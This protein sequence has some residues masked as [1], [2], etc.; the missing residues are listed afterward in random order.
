MVS[1]I[2][3]SQKVP[4][5]PTRASSS[6][7]QNS[8]TNALAGFSFSCIGQEPSFLK[9][10]S[11][12]VGMDQDEELQY[13]SYPSTPEPPAVSQVAREPV[14]N[15]TQSSTSTIAVRN[16]RP[17]RETSHEHDTAYSAYPNTF[18]PPSTDV[19]SSAHP[20]PSTHATKLT[21][22]THR[23][24]EPNQS[25]RADTMR[26]NSSPTREPSLPPQ[27]DAGL[28]S[29]RP[30]PSTS[31]GT[32]THTRCQGMRH[33]LVTQAA[34]PADLIARISQVAS[35]KVEWSEVKLLMQRYRR[36][37]DELLR[38][39]D[40]SARA[41]QKEREQAS[42][43]SAVADDAFGKFEALLLRHE[44]RLAFEQ[45][46]AE[47]ALTEI[48]SVIIDREARQAP[49]VEMEAREAV[50]ARRAQL[51]AA[52]RHRATEEGA[53]RTVEDM[54]R[55]AATE[56]R[57]KA[58]AERE[59]EERERLEADQQRAEEALRKAAEQRR[60][61]LAA[62][63]Q[64]Q[65]EAAEEERRTKYAAQ[66]AAAELEKR[67]YLKVQRL[68]ARRN[69]E[70][71]PKSANERLKARLEEERK[72]A[73][74]RSTSVSSSGALAP[75]KTDA[76]KERGS[77]YVA[78]GPPNPLLPVQPTVPISFASTQ[79][80]RIDEPQTGQ[81]NG[82]R[83]GHDS[84]MAADRQGQL[85]GAISSSVASSQQVVSDL[86]RN[87]Q[88]PQEFHPSS[89]NPQDS[90][91][92][93]NVAFRSPSASST[94]AVSKAVTA[95][96]G[97]T[98]NEGQDSS[99]S[100]RPVRSDP[101]ITAVQGVVKASYDGPS[102]QP[103]A[104]GNAQH[105]NIK[106]E[107]P[108][109]SGR[110]VGRAPQVPVP[111]A[112]TFTDRAI[113][114]HAQSLSCDGSSKDM[115]P[116]TVLSSTSNSNIN[117][118]NQEGCPTVSGSQDKTAPEPASSSSLYRR[119]PAFANTSMEL[120]A[121]EASGEVDPWVNTPDETGAQYHRQVDFHE[122]RPRPRTAYDINSPPRPVTPP[123][124]GYDHYSPPPDNTLRRDEWSPPRRKRSRPNA[125]AWRPGADDG[126]PMR[127]ARL[128][129]PNDR[130]QRRRVTAPEPHVEPV[131]VN[132]VYR[133]ERDGSSYDNGRVEV[134]YGHQASFSQ[135][136]N[137]DNDSIEPYLDDG[138]MYNE[139]QERPGD[140]AA[141][142]DSAADLRPQ[143]SL[144]Q[145]EQ[146]IQSQQSIADSKSLLARMSDDRTGVS[147]AARRRGTSTASRGRGRGNRGGRPHSQRPL[148][149]RL[150]GDEIGLGARLS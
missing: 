79:A 150:T 74:S 110:L 9:R 21:T 101:A 23:V 141:P 115:P 104:A 53:K 136:Y 108:V 67:A 128:S 76:D 84:A 54:Q 15:V 12:A 102:S 60:K 126:P 93:A 75:T 135:S 64:R 113:H 63:E 68:E 20:S 58:K 31:S 119:P 71:R 133:A 112:P 129:P 97:T 19:G 130:P 52:E 10:L 32:S 73:T 147:N 33:S 59:R 138:P 140:R 5:T 24:P 8:G 88:T 41:Y 4:G 80:T 46:Q 120:D 7:N 131:R 103:A 144:R 30:S 28:I 142:F 34:S 65:A 50:E 13:P 39:H 107:S 61:A 66:R 86:P 27:T 94:Q 40:E 1:T 123:V 146:S 137:W 127:R 49:N 29:S 139:R 148:T 55:D 143:S 116:H 83:N 36:E 51:E 22:G 47:S 77:R 98:S 37:H 17:S 96:Q 122:E 100:R 44:E 87:N 25:G 69:Q 114:D 145:A 42:K 14:L 121:V 38:R 99:A 82:E 109:D 105:V 95:S 90:P 81:L 78:S 125:D 43:V 149:S 45:Q 6:S 132:T 85:A 56:E 18:N 106:R 70:K 72:E 62:E 89:R 92:P 26:A 48:Q 35:E 124:R 118:S 134:P 2:L 57:R 11:G 3:N 16:A 91:Q 117:K 111:A